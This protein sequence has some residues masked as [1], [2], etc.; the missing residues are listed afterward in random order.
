MSINASSKATIALSLAMVL[1]S[2]GVSPPKNSRISQL[3]N[4]NFVCQNPGKLRTDSV[5]GRMPGG[6]IHGWSGAEMDIAMSHFSSIPDNYENFLA[7]LY[8]S[9][10]F[11]GIYPAPLETGS[12]GSVMGATS[13]VT[14]SDGRVFPKWI[15]I[16]DAVPNGLQF[17][18]QHEVGHAVENFIRISARGVKFQFDS[19]KKDMFQEG[20]NNPLIRGY[21]RSSAGEYFAEAFANFYCSPES[22]ELIRQ[23]LPL[24]FEFLTNVLDAP[25]WRKNGRPDRE[26]ITDY[27]YY[28]EDGTFVGRAAER[29]S[30][31]R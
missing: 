22:H 13:I 31:D 18:L 21:A 9:Q 27:G 5:T 19:K 7:G 30:V 24:T 10:D 15:Q 2:C 26:T 12:N 4:K 11:E 28:D 17:A 23:E 25:V 29:K 14:V 3:T 1:S 20:S 6:M 8:K 16:T